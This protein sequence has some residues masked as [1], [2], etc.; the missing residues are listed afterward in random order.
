MIIIK[1]DQSNATT[2]FEKHLR[3]MV[4]GYVVILSEWEDFLSNFFNTEKVN[5]KGK[6]ESLFKLN[7][8]LNFDKLP[9]FYDENEEVLIFRFKENSLILVKMSTINS[10]PKYIGKFIVMRVFFK[11]LMKKAIEEKSSR[12]INKVRL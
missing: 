11:N 1:N 9:V 3:E 6:I 2:H 5:G 7:S 10:M 4:S 8:S 12:K